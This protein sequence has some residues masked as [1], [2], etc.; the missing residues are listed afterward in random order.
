MHAGLRSTLLHHFRIT[1][2]LFTISLL[3]LLKMCGHS[4]RTIAA[5]LKRMIYGQKEIMATMTVVPI[6]KVLAATVA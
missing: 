4:N 5:C 2:K 6:A 1:L 3:W